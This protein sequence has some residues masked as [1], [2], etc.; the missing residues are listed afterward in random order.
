MLKVNKK[1]WPKGPQVPHANHPW[2][3]DDFMVDLSCTV[4]LFKGN[5]KVTSNSLKK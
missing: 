5:K 4:A 2:V 3:T 1:V